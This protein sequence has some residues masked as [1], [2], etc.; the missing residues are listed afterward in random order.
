MPARMGLRS[1]HAV[2]PRRLTF[3]IVGG[4]ILGGGIGGELA[5]AT[6]RWSSGGAGYVATGIVA[7]LGIGLFGCAF[8]PGQRE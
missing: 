2:D 3:A 5:L 4:L 6:S 8:V 1:H 7:G